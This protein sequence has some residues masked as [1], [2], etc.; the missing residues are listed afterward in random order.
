M[1]TGS[2]MTIR[3]QRWK[4]RMGVCGFPLIM[5]S[6]SDKAHLLNPTD[7]IDVMVERAL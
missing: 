7:T 2:T 6:L 4:W 1:E 5:S 3:R